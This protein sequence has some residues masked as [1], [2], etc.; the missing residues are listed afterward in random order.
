MPGGSGGVNGGTMIAAIWKGAVALIVCLV[1][2]DVIGVV[3][4][5]WF[6]IKPFGGNSAALPYA[7]W[8]VGGIFAGA[9]TLILA[10]RWITANES[11]MDRPEAPGI[12]ARI[13]MVCAP[14][15]AAL[16]FFFWRIYWSQGVAGEYF[17]PDSMPHSLTYFLSALTVFVAAPFILTSKPKP[18]A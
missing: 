16:I 11:W 9:F 7:I 15:L 18:P 5:V 12:A 3:A 4:C 17:V 8:F 10:G 13:L 6:D 2:I 1:V 14:I